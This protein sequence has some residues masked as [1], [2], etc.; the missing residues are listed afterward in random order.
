MSLSSFLKDENWYLKS[1]FFILFSILYLFL[2][3]LPLSFFLKDKNLQFTI[4]LSKILLFLLLYIFRILQVDK[5]VLLALLNNDNLDRLEKA[6]P[7]ITTPQRIEE[8]NKGPNVPLHK[9][10]S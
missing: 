9:E 2:A 1:Y 10:G 4:L 6:D 8:L 5:T 7:N 3:V